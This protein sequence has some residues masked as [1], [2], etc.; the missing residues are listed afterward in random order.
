MNF[1]HLEEAMELV[2]L[3]EV[4][5]EAVENS[6]GILCQLRWAEIMEDQMLLGIEILKGLVIAQSLTGSWATGH[7]WENEISSDQ[8]AVTMADQTPAEITMGEMTLE[9]WVASIMHETFHPGI[10]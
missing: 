5:C 9:L 6:G 1:Q 4:L 2:M 7:Q 8:M 10:S 3:I